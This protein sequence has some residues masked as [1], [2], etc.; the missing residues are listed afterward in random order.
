MGALKSR[1]VDLYIPS[2]FTNAKSNWQLALPINR[3]LKFNARCLFHV[4]KKEATAVGNNVPHAVLDPPDAD[5]TWS[6]K[7]MLLAMP[8]MDELHKRSSPLAEDMK[9]DDAERYEHPSK[10]MF[11]Q[12]YFFRFIE[13]PV[14]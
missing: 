2:D 13:K 3:P 6:V 9:R 7:V 14:K 8:D 5:F 4:M 11:L 10:G 1:Y 12:P